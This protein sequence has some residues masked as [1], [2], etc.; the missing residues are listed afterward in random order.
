[1]LIGF[2]LV[3]TKAARRKALRELQEIEAVDRGHFF[4]GQSVFITVRSR[5]SR[6]GR[7]VPT[8]PQVTTGRFT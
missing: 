8:L 5:P 6:H 1:M 7:D 4:L 2:V 3:A